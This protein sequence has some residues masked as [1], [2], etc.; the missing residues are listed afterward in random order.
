MAIENTLSHVM[1]LVVSNKRE[2]LSPE[3]DFLDVYAD[4][5]N[6]R[7][8]FSAR[9][10]NQSGTFVNQLEVIASIY[11]E[12]QTESL[13][14]TEASGMQMVPHSNFAFPIPLNGESFVPGNYVLHLQANSGELKWEWTRSF[15]VDDHI[16]KTF[17]RQD[18]TIPSQNKYWVL[19]SIFLVIL[20]LLVLFML[21]ATIKC[22]KMAI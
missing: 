10:Q 13:Y 18:I 2:Q 14:S 7:N 15:E 8:V 3:L 5:L 11:N 4:Q 1:G 9:I 16:S 21:T 20:L 19:V 17:N 6:F 12:D 22:R